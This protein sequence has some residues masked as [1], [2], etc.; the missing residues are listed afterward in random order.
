MLV[1]RGHC[2]WID[3]LQMGQALEYIMADTWRKLAQ[4]FDGGL[5]CQLADYDGGDGRPFTLNEAHQGLGAQPSP[6]EPSCLCMHA[7]MHSFA[8][9]HS[10]RVA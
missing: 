8:S 5:R 10:H 3:V 2:L 6:A 9:L 1:N 4:D 7:C